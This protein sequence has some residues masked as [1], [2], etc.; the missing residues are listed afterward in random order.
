MIAITTS[1]SMSVKAFQD[2][3]RRCKWYL[4]MDETLRGDY[5]PIEEEGPNA[6]AGDPCPESR[7]PAAQKL[8]HPCDGAE[9]TCSESGAYEFAATP[10]RVRDCPEY[11][12]D[13]T[14]SSRKKCEHKKCASGG[15]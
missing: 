12:R 1:S 5:L 10:E 15:N 14:M 9:A 11:L 13:G 2:H 7:S 3:Q 6:K 4:G 8:G